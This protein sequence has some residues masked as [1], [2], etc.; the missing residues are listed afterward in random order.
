MSRSS[1][2]LAALL[3]AVA[4]CATAARM[5][6][7]VEV[8]STHGDALANV[9]DSIAGLINSL[10]TPLVGRHREKSGPAFTVV[11]YTVP[12][13]AADDFEEAWLDLERSTMD[14]DD[15]PLYN[16]RKTRTDNLF[17][18]G[19]AEWDSMQDLRDHVLSKHFEDFADS[20]DELGVR[21]QLEILGNE[22]EDIEEDS[23]NGRRKDQ[24]QQGGDWDDNIPEEYR[25]YIPEQYRPQHKRHHR[26]VSELSNAAL[27]TL[28]N[29]TD[30]T[31][32]RDLKREL[33][34]G[35]RGSK[36]RDVA[37]VLIQYF[38]PPER[39]EDF[40]DEWLNAAEKTI[41]ED[42]NRVWSLRKVKSD[43]SRY[44]AYGTW[45]SVEDLRD[46]LESKHVQK[47]LD[48]YDDS[49]VVYFAVPVV[50]IGKE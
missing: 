50:P 27:A 2:V 21:W 13:S 7:M 6:P 22:S 26:K 8:A 24:G 9:R 43:N 19:Y 1:L 38:V 41:E 11:K 33:S 14:K 29:P 36:G 42:G 44:Y 46:H 15:P 40:V 37:H 10:S 31:A 30:A 5:N 49:D 4:G 23:R 34:R 17:Y 45:D 12:P 3:L 32:V 18:Y 16:L 39:R 47:L 35:R 20:V 48:F 28:P 25:K